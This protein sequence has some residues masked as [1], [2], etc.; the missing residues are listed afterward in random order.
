[1]A[2]LRLTVK[3]TARKI[4]IKKLPVSQ[5]NCPILHFHQ[6]CMSSVFSTPTSGF[7]MDILLNFVHSNRCVVMGH[8]NLSLRLLIGW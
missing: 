5:N 4:D 6:Q 8:H 7:G 2:G 3:E 1:M